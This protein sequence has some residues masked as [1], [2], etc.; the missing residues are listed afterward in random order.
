MATS[1]RKEIISQLKLQRHILTA[2]G[3]APSPRA[4]GKEER[5]LRD[6]ITCLNV[7]EEEERHPCN[8]CLLW[9]WVP[10]RHRYREV[11][12]HYIPLD[13]QGRGI[14]ELEAAGERQQAEK[15]L[16]A[17]LDSTI[18]ALEAKTDCTAVGSQ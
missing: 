1:D 7:F 15:C 18:Q 13:A 17:W 11:P 9:D 10:E 8:Q 6:S 5:L 14:A 16:R 3:Y 12:C 4:G 2:G